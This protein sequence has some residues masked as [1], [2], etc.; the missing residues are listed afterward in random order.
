MTQE[1]V[2][3]QTISTKETG[4][5]LELAVA[6]LF[7]V[8][9]FTTERNMHIAQYQIDVKATVG[10]RTI[11]VECK[12]YQNSSLT[13]RNLI[14]QW[15]SKN[16][17]IK[18]HKII[19]VLAG[20]NIKVADKALAE[21]FDIELWSQ[22]DLT[23]LFNLSLKPAEL[24]TRLFSKIALQPLTIAERY[25]EAITYLV[26]RP[27]LTGQGITEER[28]YSFFNKA[29]RSHVITN[30]QIESTTASERAKHIELF[31]DTK[32][33]KGF[34]Q[35]K[36]KRKEKDY[37]DLVWEKLSSEQI[38]PPELQE[39]YLIHMSDLIE[40][41]NA[42]Q[43]YFSGDDYFG[44]TKLLI[45]SRLRN[46]LIAGQECQFKTSKMNNSIRVLMSSDQYFT[47]YVSQ[48]DEKQA[49]IMNWILTSEYKVSYNPTAKTTT[50]YWACSS[51]QET[52]DKIFRIITEFYQLSDSDSIWDLAM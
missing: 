1:N 37:W 48:L 6:H 13:I 8:A 3:S 39:S 16:Q 29:L 18:A 27:L 42:Q 38:L 20:V 46:A 49:N 23:E 35:V 19:L 5:S 21:D 30:L 43:S 41:Y 2:T 33:K 22:D 44:K 26:I 7:K 15:S 50:H 9:G 52:A 32:S 36:K 31:E 14:H 12:N 24:R 10:D 17:L 40:E 25:R 47:I 4:D 45:N 11:I 34:F 51:L 28:L